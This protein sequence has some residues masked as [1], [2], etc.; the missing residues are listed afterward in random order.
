M[1]EFGGMDEATLQRLL[2]LVREHTGVHMVDAKK[3]M[4]QARLRPRM[5]GLAIASYAGYVEYLE[6]HGDERAHFID[7]VTMHQTAFFRTP[8]VWQYFSGVFLPGWIGQGA[9]RPLRIWSAAASTGEEACTIAICCEEARRRHPGFAYEI[10]GTDIS[11][12]VLAQARA[13]RY[14]G[15]SVA[16]FR[17]SHPDLFERHDAARQPGHFMLEPPVRQRMAFEP[18]NLLA[19]GPWR[20]HFD[21]VFLRNVLIYFTAEDIRAVVRHLAPALRARGTLVIGESESLTSLDVP[22]QFVQ[23][24]IYERTAA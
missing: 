23:P 1:P 16:G 13:G 3:T 21:I 17:A 10:L 24:Q 14:E 9:G 7:A 2:G 4:L 5:R 19:P 8:K 6:R 18:H 22:F 12:G 15:S 11:T 20:D